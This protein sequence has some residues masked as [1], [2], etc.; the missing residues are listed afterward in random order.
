MSQSANKRHQ[1][2]AASLLILGAVLSGCGSS[3]EKPVAVGTGTDDMKRSPCA[4][5][6][7]EL[8]PTTDAERRALAA[9]IL[10]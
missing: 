2:S 7:L 10:S 3:T 8:A 5:I 4:C 6:D 1:L 9:E